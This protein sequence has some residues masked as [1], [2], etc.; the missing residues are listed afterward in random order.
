MEDI[1]QGSSRA[2][3]LL[4]LTPQSPGDSSHIVSALIMLTIPTFA[5]YSR[6]PLHVLTNTVS[7]AAGPLNLETWV[8]P[9]SAALFPIYPHTLNHTLADPS[10]TTL[11]TAKVTLLHFYSWTS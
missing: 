5:P 11:H 7:T 3:A 10:L 4:S 2:L 9:S 6:L 1:E 8:S